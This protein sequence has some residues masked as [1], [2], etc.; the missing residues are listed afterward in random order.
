M[1][2]LAACARIQIDGPSR[3]D[4]MHESL[5]TVVSGA[6]PAYVKPDPEGARLWKQTRT[7]YEERE[8]LPAW[9][10]NAKARPQMA[11]L[12]EALREADRDGLDPE[13][14]N[15]SMLEQRHAEA[16]K[17][18]LSEKGFDPREAGALD[19]WLTYLYMKYA[20]DLA[21]GLSDLARADPDLADRDREVR[22][23]GASREGA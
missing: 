8:F 6:A 15:V 18:F 2:L 14:Y 5:R 22:R 12:I 3:D 17:G 1:A 21:D 16:R 10:E 4:Q 7:F 19:V 23:E 9:V 13:L 11:S 20:S